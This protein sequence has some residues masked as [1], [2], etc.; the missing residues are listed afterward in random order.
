MTSLR[1]KLS[2]IVSR[3]FVECGLDGAYGTVSVSNR[4]ELG[5]FQCNGALAAAKKHG[6]N[7]RE[8][9]DAVVGRLDPLP[10]IASTSVAGPGFINITVDDSFLVAHL[11]AMSDERL[12]V[13]RVANPTMVIIDY[14]G[15]NVAKPL[16]VG[17]LR[18][19]IIGESMKRIIKF[20][21][22]DVIGD[23]HLGDWGLQM[24]MVISEIE[25][26]C[27]TL[28]Y[29]DP[30]HTGP[31]PVASPVT[32]EEL[33]EIYPAASGR[34]KSD[35]GALEEARRV[36]RELQIGRSGYRALW[37]HIH[38][39]SVA[40]LR[41][42]YTDL[43]ISFDLWL[44]ESDTQERIP[45][46]IERLTEAGYAVRSEGALV[47]YVN[48]ETDTR[49]FPPLILAKSDGAALYATTDLATIE[50]RMEK[51]APD[52]ILYLTDKRQIDHFL[53]VFRAARKTGIAPDERVALEHIGF[54][55][56]NGSDGKPFKTRSGGVMKL[57]DLIRMLVE[58]ALER[59]DEAEV[60]S[61]YPDEEKREIARKVGV[62]AL[63]F[64]D[65]MNQPSKDYV[66]DL[67]R[68][69][70]FEGKTGPYLLYNAV[71]IKSIL[72]KASE[73]GLTVGPLVS[74]ASAVERSLFERLAA[75]PDQIESAFTQRAPH[76]L[77]EYGYTLAN[78]FAGFY[79]DHH[80][81]RET[82]PARRSSWLELSRIVLR[83]IEIVT[84]LLGIELPE[85]M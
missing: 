34:C 81:L 10:E 2:D 21:G 41:K 1:I 55:T 27:P 23:V 57:K 38:D 83:A 26:R 39:V 8:I 3:C 18:S 60:A 77:C 11:R 14:G 59:M 32:P 4:P 68:F 71:R 52:R 40:D 64:G 82:D 31:Y 54:G 45:S 24:G 19:G 9:A 7:P 15:A 63:K 58:K 12:G 29:F 17:H 43:G 61:D 35:E 33:E 28:P 65:L 48:E 25:R 85:R 44:G 50:D 5:Q 51:Y 47:V 42:D 62:A 20:L 30:E 53:Q 84:D 79:R 56:M 13:D 66:F 37:Q 46:L 6:R 36:T 78:E 72:R 80:I 74:P 76:F 73:Q 69:A 16:H 22:H 67:D 75:F 70:S 49:E